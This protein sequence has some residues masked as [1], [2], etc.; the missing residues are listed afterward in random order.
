LNRPARLGLRD[1]AR[2]QSASGAPVAIFW[3]QRICYSASLVLAYLAMACGCA[4]RRGRRPGLHWAA[5]FAPTTWQG[6][7]AGVAAQRERAA[8]VAGGVARHCSATAGSLHRGAPAGNRAGRPGRLAGVAVRRGRR[9]W[10]RR[11]LA[12]GFGCVARAVL[13]ARATA[14]CHAGGRR[15]RVRQPVPSA[16]LSEHPIHR[17]HAALLAGPAGWCCAVGAC[18]A[19]GRRV[20]QRQ[21]LLIACLQPGRS[22]VQAA[23]GLVAARPGG[24]AAPCAASGS[25]VRTTR[26]RAS[27]AR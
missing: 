18:R 1:A 25:G 12:P 20:R 21:S 4:H 5:G 9:R 14:C 15:G 22:G 2:T 11:S 16:G 8:P 19:G 27:A 7:A 26:R 23:N 3:R 6:Q 13:F 24:L 17:P 10:Q